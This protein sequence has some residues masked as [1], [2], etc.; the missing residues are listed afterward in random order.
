MASI[1]IPVHSAIIDWVLQNIHEEQ[2]A[3]EVT[4]RLNAWKNGKKTPTLNQLKEMSRKT[5]IPFGYFFLQAPPQEDVPLVEYR[6]VGSTK[7]KKPSRNLI[8]VLDQMTAIQDWM[9]DELQSDGTNPLP[10]VGT[11]HVHDSINQ[12]VQKIR[13]RLHL[14]IHWYKDGKIAEENFNNLRNQ[15]T[16]CGVLVF[17]GG[18]VG[19]NT[20]RRLDINE[21]RAFTLVDAHAPL[22]FINTADAPNGRLF[23][24]LHETA[25][26]FFGKNSLFN[27]AEW[28]SHTVNLLEQ[29]CNAVASEI[30]VP[31]EEFQHIWNPSL[32]LTEMM[33]A[34]ARHFRCSEAVILRRAYDAGKITRDEYL[35]MMSMQK[36]RYQKM[37]AKKKRSGGDFY[38]TLLSNIDRR[39]LTA[40]HRSLLRGTTQD[41]DAYRL[42]GLNRKTYTTAIAKMGGTQV[43]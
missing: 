3:S 2:P 43:E 41:T 16:R 17:T 20:R 25:H 9:R 1:T 5:H 19:C 12:T 32:P 33:E 31:E 30:L 14:N 24:L 39:F 18:K 29:K 37:N 42:T 34:A 6:T 10:F 27:H 40:L 22:I 13:R 8:D 15:L 38:N 36:A 35:R 7:G 4:E 11:A 26:I 28:S 23:S 21:F